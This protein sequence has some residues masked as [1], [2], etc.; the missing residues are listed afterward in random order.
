[1]SHPFSLTSA[2]LWAAILH[3][4][5]REAR[6]AQEQ[7]AA[8]TTLA[9]EQGFTQWV[10]WGTILHGWALAAQGQHEGGVAE[11]RQGLAAAPLAVGGKTWQPYFLGL[12]AE[13][14]WEGGHPEEGLNALTEAL[15][16]ME[17]TQA[18]Y[19]GAELYRLQ[20]TLLLNAACGVRHAALTPEEC[21]QKALCIARD[22]HAKTLELRA[23]TSLARLWQSQ[24][25]RQDAHDLLAPVY[26]WFTEGFDTAD[27]QD[28]QTLLKELGC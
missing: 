3:Q 19:Y 27:L 24:D 28:A 16:V 25:K 8:A 17:T 22:Q 18:R 10:A 7:A 6:A 23:S 21:F 20:G 5:R 14:N 2:L 26:D 12:L 1:M 9:T 4:C 11:I 15:A 13:V